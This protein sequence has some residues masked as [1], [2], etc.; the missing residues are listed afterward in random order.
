MARSEYNVKEQWIGTGDLTDYTFDFKI[1]DLSQLL[2]ILQDASGAQVSKVRGDDTT[3]LASVTFDPI[4]G[5]GTISLKTVLAI[6]YILTA[7]LAN[8]LPTQPSRFR[9]RASVTMKSFEMAL[10]WL[11]GA[12]QRASYLSVRSV[13]MDDLDDID[14]FDPTLPLG[15][16]SNPLATLVVNDTGTG[17]KFGATLGQIAEATTNAAVALAAAT[18]AAASAVAAAAS[19]AAAAASAISA[20]S[21]F[22]VTGSG[23]VPLG[24]TAA[25]GITWAGQNRQLTHVHG[26]PGAV[27]ISANPQI[28]AGTAEGNEL[29][30][31]GRD[32]TN[33]VTITNGN[34][35]RLNGDIILGDGDVLGLIWSNTN[36]KWEE[37]YRR[38]AT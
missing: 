27:T 16:G 5:S 1:E 35:L 38:S 2:I 4:D 21:G 18:A 9:E 22:F 3:I 12:L 17:F 23:T 7:L 31:I 33:T 26:S 24:I 28:S 19:A 10:D 8:D 25:G 29:T 32:D 11:G 20:Q 13:K 37:I 14:N 30:I 6:D 34:G 36:S 15:V